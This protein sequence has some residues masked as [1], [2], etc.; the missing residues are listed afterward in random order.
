MAFEDRGL[1]TGGSDDGGGEPDQHEAHNTRQA[2]MQ[3]ETVWK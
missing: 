1:Q 2:K 3:T